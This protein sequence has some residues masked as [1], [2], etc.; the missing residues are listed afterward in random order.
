MQAPQ[1]PGQHPMK[2]RGDYTQAAADY[3][4]TSPKAHR[5][6][7]DLERVMRTEYL[8]D[9]FQ[10]T[11][12]V[13]ANL[14]QLFHAGYDVDFSPLYKQ[15]ADTKGIASHIVLPTDRRIAIDR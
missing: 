11:Y 9:D 13:L 2:L 7:F 14:E 5:I 12:F 1:A 8:I 15:Y 10:S 6:A 3:T 4:V